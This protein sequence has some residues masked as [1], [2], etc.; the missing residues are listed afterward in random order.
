[1][2]N[3][4]CRIFCYD[5][6]IHILMTWTTFNNYNFVAHVVIVV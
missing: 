1:M 2:E 4:E 6:F 3:A 5:A